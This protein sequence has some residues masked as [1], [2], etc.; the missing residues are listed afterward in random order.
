M[1]TITTPIQW[2]I[3]QS[4][5]QKKERAYLL[6]KAS[7]FLF[8]LIFIMFSFL[9]FLL[10]AIIIF[11]IIY[12]IQKNNKLNTSTSISNKYKISESGIEVFNAS[13]K[14]QSTYLW[15]NILSFYSF[16][17]TGPIGY[18]S[19]S[20]LGNDFV[21][22]NKQKNQIILKTNKV[23]SSTVKMALL[24]KIKKKTPPQTENIFFSITSKNLSLTKKN[25]SSLITAPVAPQFRNKTA[26]EK[27]IA[28]KNFYQQ[29]RQYKQGMQKRKD[30]LQRNILIFIYITLIFVVTIVY[31]T[32]S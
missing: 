23:N 5:N 4:Q 25:N 2:E 31:L 7:G 1:K 30:S 22:I 32:I 27:S 3:T 12:F 11:G 13:D 15:E 10:V 19:S 8:L 16:S 24:K 14:K 28:E 18:I 29:Q 9:G 26:Q 6:S 20:F 17:E 21:L